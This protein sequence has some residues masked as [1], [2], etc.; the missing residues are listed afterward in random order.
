MSYK[1]VAILGSTGSIG[2]N[3]LR[4]IDALGEQHFRV[5]AL[6]AGKNID[7]LADQIARYLPDVVSVETESAA[8]QLRTQLFQRDLDLPRIVIGEAGLCEIAMHPQ[9]DCVVSATVGAVGFVPTLR[10][11]ECG[12]R[13]AL[14]NKETLVMA[15]E[16]MTRAAEA[17]GAE[18]L[19]VD[20]EHNALHQCLRGE[21]RSE[22][23]RIILTASG[24]PFRTR[25]K[26]DMEQATVADAL[27]HP[28]WDMGDKITIDSATLM[29]KGLEVIEAR[30][31]FGFDADHIGI[32][33]H[34]E[35][36][37]HSMIELIDGS[38]IA[39]MGVTDMRHAIQY[40]LTYPE[41]HA[42][43]LPPLDLTTLSTL[44]FEAPDIERFPCVA[45]AYRALRTG[46]TLPAAMNA[47]NEEAVGAFIE[48]RI[49][50]TDIPRVIEAV[51]DAHDTQPLANLETV[52]ATDRSARRAA[53]TEI[54][55]LTNKSAVL[56]ERMV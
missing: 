50:L 8:H 46:G 14:A 40:A 36:V 18:L 16:L 34:P 38:V 30:W 22:V 35:S 6:G 29:N 49:A 25:S 17:S 5:V 55:K 15:G 12:K 31:L 32:V 10:A 45:L 23:R 2:C 42:C 43:E 51:M 41:R 44:H 19:P 33:V 1:G 48:E 56:A 47:A 52:L 7:L 3:T 24:G 4:V 39:Q 28:T 20:S 27:R 26:A 53:S 9:A 21:K 37:V 11:L 54:A 13:V